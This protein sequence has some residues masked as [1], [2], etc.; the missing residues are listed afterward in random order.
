MHFKLLD[1]L[2]LPG[3]K[4]PFKLCDFTMVS[5]PTDKSVVVIGGQMNNEENTYKQIKSNALIELSGDSI[6]TLKWTVLKQKL[7]YPR[8]QHLAFPISPQTST[9]LSEKYENLRKRKLT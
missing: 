5:S 1:A 2:I 3:P 8:F 6:D 7:K 9:E 4:L